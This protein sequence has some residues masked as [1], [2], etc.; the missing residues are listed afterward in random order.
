MPHR[1]SHAALFDSEKAPANL[2]IAYQADLP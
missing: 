2:T 1:V